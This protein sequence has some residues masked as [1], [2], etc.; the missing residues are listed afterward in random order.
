[1]SGKM[2]EGVMDGCDVRALSYLDHIPFTFSG[3]IFS[4]S[5]NGLE[6]HGSRRG[7]S[8]MAAKSL[9]WWRGRTEEREEGGKRV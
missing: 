8:L 3:I 2:A 4:V 6:L 9:W 5:T 7:K 1:M